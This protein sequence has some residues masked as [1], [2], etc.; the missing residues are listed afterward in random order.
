MPQELVSSG[1]PG[2]DYLLGGGFPARRMYLV[3]GPTGSGKT[4]LGA[5]FAIEGVRANETTLYVTLAESHEEMQQV[6]ESHGGGVEVASAPGQGA[7]FTIWLP[8]G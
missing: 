2:L 6:A 1:I 4:T 5:Q 8:L 3:H 7:T